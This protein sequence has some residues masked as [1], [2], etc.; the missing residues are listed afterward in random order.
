MKRT[1]LFLATA[2]TLGL[3]TVT[4]SALAGGLVAVGG[5]APSANAWGPVFGYSGNGPVYYGEYAPVAYDSYAFAYQ[6]PIYSGSQVTATAVELVNGRF[7]HRRVVGP[8]L[9][10]IAAS[11]RADIA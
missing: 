6:Y 5:L 3:S 10:I 1:A 7:R 2:A 11:I 8:A 4:T 9:P